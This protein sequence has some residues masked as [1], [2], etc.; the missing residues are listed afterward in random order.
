MLE[1]LAEGT[2]LQR[3]PSEKTWAHTT[4]EL[5]LGSGLFSKGFKQ[6]SDVIQWM[7]KKI[8]I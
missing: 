8:L 3:S 2:V 6:W 7:F 5:E 4:L 1:I